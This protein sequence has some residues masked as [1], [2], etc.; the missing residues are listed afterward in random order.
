MADNITIKDGTGASVVV[1]TT[2]VGAGVEASMSIPT[3]TA[4][5]AAA[6]GSGVNGATVPRVALATDSPGVTTL[7]QTT[8]SASLPVALASDQ[9]LAVY[10]ITASVAVTPTVT[11]GNYSG[12]NKSIGGIMTFASI[13]PATFTGVLQSI[14]VKF[15]ATVI[16]QTI[17][18]AVFKASP[19]NGTYTDTNF[20]YNAADA[21]NLVG[22][23]YIIP[24]GTAWAGST[25]TFCELD[26]IGHAF[27]GTSASLFAV[28][29]ASATLGNALASTSDMTVEIGVLQG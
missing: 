10:G 27:T 28:V 3:N 29:T 21:A 19:S 7:G 18:V 11:A 24:V 22:A 23:P 15:K 5:N 13:L 17:T 25:S 20:T 16:V 2:D 4:G 14:T 12:G 8:K 9:L 6:F 26:G 1:R